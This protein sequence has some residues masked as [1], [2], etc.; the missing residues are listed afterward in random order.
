MIDDERFEK[1]KCQLLSVLDT[2]VLAEEREDGRIGECEEVEEEK[3]E[4]QSVEEEKEEIQKAE[5][6]KE[7]IRKP[8]SWRWR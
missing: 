8:S 2:T 3:E 6:E 4:V 5:E 7:E 1:Q